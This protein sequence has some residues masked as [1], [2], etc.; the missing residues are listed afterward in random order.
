IAM[1]Y[2][3]GENLDAHI[4]RGPLKL[5]EATGLALD[6][7]GALSES[8]AKAVV[9]RDIKPA[10]IIV[11]EKGHAVVLDFGLAMLKG[12][13]RLTREGTTVG[14]VNYMSPEQAKGDEVDRR[15]DIWSLGVVLYQMI[16]GQLP[17]KGDHESAV[18]YSI[19]NENPE[20]VTALRTG[21]P[22]ELER[23]VAKALAKVPGE[24]YQNIDD[25]RVD[26]A[27]LQKSM[28]ADTAGTA[29][30][31]RDASL[32]SRSASR[33]HKRVFGLLLVAIAVFA[34]VWFY[35]RVVSKDGGK[36]TDTAVP[37][38]I[39][40]LLDERQTSIAVLPLA[41]LSGDDKNEFFADGMTEEIITQLAQI[42]ALKVISRTSV[43]RYKG[44]DV[45]ITAI[46]KELNVATVLEGSVLWAGDRV[47]I[48]AQ[49]ID[50]ATDENL[51]ANS[52]ESDLEDILGLQNRVATDVAREI[53]VELTDQE[54]TQLASSPTVNKNAYQLYLKGRH[55]WG[56]RTPESLQKAIGY[57]TNALNADPNY[58]LAYAGLGQCY[59]V[60]G[61]WDVFTPPDEIYP[62]AREYAEKALAIDPNLGAAHAVLGGIATEYD[63]DWPAAESHFE[64]ALE[65]KPNDAT[66]HQWYAEH[67][68][69][70][71]RRQPALQHIEIARE[72]DP[73]SLV[74]LAVCIN[75]YTAFEQPSK[76][77]EAFQTGID[78]DPN[79]PPLYHTLI[80]SYLHQGEYD[81]AIETRLR[82]LDLIAVGDV[83]R[84][85]VAKG[86]A[87]YRQNGWR[88]FLR[89]AIKYLKTR[90]QQDYAPPTLIAGYHAMFGEAD[91]AM[92]WL[93]E[94][95]RRRD[96][97]IS[98]L[99][100]YPFLYPL[101]DDPR[102]IALLK[103]LKLEDAINPVH[104]KKWQQTRP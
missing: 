25:I 47:R 2:I 26:L 76:S 51:W 59:L 45:P 58:A 99:S 44:T 71:G 101:Y 7:C 12:R 40:S 5:D 41:N 21:I 75:V 20:P 50:G 79:Y 97:W 65:I 9:H 90:Y 62:K 61:T 70:M 28:S 27:N 60:M 82:Y 8:H 17:F 73:L 4:E 98:T 104:G 86:K 52:Y 6:L 83:E 3:P 43:M 74:V 48:N 15:T 55:F 24:R 94:G 39:S 14:T 72:L 78:I 96:P 77:E 69:R 1:A 34:A 88:G 85:L 22:M 36:P 95:Y 30:T 16:T 103:Q 54:T 80:Y 102:F 18:V 93:D 10:N 66:T 81:K 46:A 63:W 68:W 91:S 19:I 31:L 32:E 53:K 64:R 57:Y 37:T 89:F 23:I 100:R 84:A 11:S 35:P 38:T 33:A 49:L 92:V 42:S 13:T 67:W 56:K 29:P 87:A